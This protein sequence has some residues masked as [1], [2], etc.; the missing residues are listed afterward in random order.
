MHRLLK[1]QLE[2]A[3]GADGEVSLPRLLELVSAAYTEQE[4]NRKRA[5][6]A[7]ELMASELAEM[8][9][10]RE[11]SSRLENERL[12][13]EAASA[14]KSR[15]LA[16]ISH[17][18]RTP[19]NAIIGYA[20]IIAEECGPDDDTQRLDAGRISD[21]GKHLLKLVNGILDLAR[22]EAGKMPVEAVSFAPD[23]LVEEVAAIL[24]PLARENGDE[25]RVVVSGSLPLCLTD[26][27]KLRQCLL[28]LVGN[29]LKFTKGGL[30]TISAEACAEGGADWIAFEVSDTGIGMSPAVLGRLFEP[31]S[32]AN[33]A[34]VRNYGGS[35]LGLALTKEMAE[36]IGG[37]VA[38]Q[39]IEGR[40]SAFRLCVPAY[41]PGQEAEARTPPV[42]KP[43]SALAA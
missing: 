26:H 40:G 34:T 2:R 21:A 7:N 3:R 35:G 25:L 36:L 11:L 6:R 31:F 5:D 10:I 16:T 8:L 38:V 20:E 17:E 32:Q 37:S 41:L 4:Q 33:E 24:Q 39:S 23:E 30:V 22:I 12:V 29:A 13:A 9:E 15:F 42:L 1:R 19:L 27:M 43:G 14:A 28:N 18:L